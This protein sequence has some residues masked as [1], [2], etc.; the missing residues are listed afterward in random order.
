VNARWLGACASF[1][2]LIHCFSIPFILLIAPGIFRVVP[3][4]FLHELE[5]I[6]WIVA[7]DLG[8]Y[9][10]KDASVSLG[11]RRAFFA[12]AV[13]VPPTIYFGKP[14]LTQSLLA[15]M[16]LMQFVLVLWSHRRQSKQELECCHDH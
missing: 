12:L 10:M 7:L 11:W 8:L 5:L 3:F 16:A 4:Q 15:A 13:L 6:F 1:L 2:C 14:A 9:S